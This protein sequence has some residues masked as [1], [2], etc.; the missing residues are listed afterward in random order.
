MSICLTFLSCSDTSHM[1]LML[2]INGC[3]SYDYPGH[4]ERLHS[5]IYLLFMINYYLSRYILL[6]YL[7]DT[8]LMCRTNILLFLLYENISIGSG[9]GVP[10]GSGIRR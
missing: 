1:V 2:A 8:H 3:F 5:Y 10:L 7:H 6:I 4:I 9:V